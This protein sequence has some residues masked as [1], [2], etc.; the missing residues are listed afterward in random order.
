MEEKDK[1][2]KDL[3]NHLKDFEKKYNELVDRFEI[4]EKELQEA[5]QK[6]KDLM[7][8]EIIGD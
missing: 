3:Q 6:I 1:V 4:N 2:I 7:T 5:N 8:F